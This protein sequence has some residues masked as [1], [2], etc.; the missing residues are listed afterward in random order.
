MQAEKPG[1]FWWMMARSYEASSIYL[2][3]RLYFANELNSRNHGC[4]DFSYY[5]TV[6][7]LATR[8]W[9]TSCADILPL[10]S[11]TSKESKKT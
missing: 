2:C 7:S 3:P 10:F 8:M 9:M 5:M 11:T 1:G 6:P 4:F